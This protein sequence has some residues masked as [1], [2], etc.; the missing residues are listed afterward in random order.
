MITVKRETTESIITVTLDSPPVKEGYRSAI[1]TPMPFLNHMIEHIVWRSA[2]NIGVSIETG[3]FDL[4]HVICEDVGMT[5][6][7]AVLQYTQVNRENGISGYGDGVGIIDEA[8]ATAAISF[9]S[10]S[11]F[12]FDSLVDVPSQT[13]GTL[14]EDLSTFFDGF[15]QGGSCTIHLA[16]ERGTNGHHIWE[17]AFR[18]FGIAVGKAIAI[19]PGRS[20]MTPGVA[21][22]SKYTLEPQNE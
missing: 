6:G 3:K 5:I 21:G 13:E 1:N 7:K 22:E 9:E 10:R 11:L 8:R 2:L 16:I 20:N 18:A 4:A 17:A 19:N 15:A 14:S 12:V